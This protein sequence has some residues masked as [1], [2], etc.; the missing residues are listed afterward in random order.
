M[1]RVPLTD[2]RMADGF[3]VT[4]TPLNKLSESCTTIDELLHRP[5]AVQSKELGSKRAARK[6]ALGAEK[7]VEHR[8]VD[9]LLDWIAANTRYDV[10]EARRNKPDI[11]FCDFGEHLD[12][13]HKDLVVESILRGPL[14]Q[15]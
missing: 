10:S 8:R 7:L 11:S 5:E 13:E 3:R 6:T 14:R 1:P 2:N 15:G 12:Y 4:A 9:D